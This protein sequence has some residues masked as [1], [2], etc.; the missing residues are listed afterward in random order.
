MK[1][2]TILIAIISLN[3]LCACSKKGSTF[4]LGST[5][6]TAILVTNETVQNG[7]FVVTSPET[8]EACKCEF[9][10]GG[11]TALFLGS[12]IQNG[13]FQTPSGCYVDIENIQR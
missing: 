3:S 9:V 5:A 2:L 12:T 8:I 6:E 10:L 1:S 7:S 13:I 4:T 11:P